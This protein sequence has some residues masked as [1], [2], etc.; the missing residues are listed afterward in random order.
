MVRYIVQSW[1]DRCDADSGESQTGPE[2]DSNVLE[3][4]HGDFPE[5]SWYLSGD[6]HSTDSEE[7]VPPKSGSNICQDQFDMYNLDS[8]VGEPTMNSDFQ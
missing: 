2:E 7:S 4:C 3:R 6:Q 1:L 5:F 8:D